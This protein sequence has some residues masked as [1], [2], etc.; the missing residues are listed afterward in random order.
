MDAKLLLEGINDLVEKKGISKDDVLT[1][2]KEAIIKAY[3]K[4]IGDAGD[5]RIDLVITDETFDLQITKTVVKDEDVDVDYLDIALSEAKKLKKGVKVGDEIAVSI[6]L[7]VLTRVSTN[8]VKSVLKQKL[9]EAEKRALFEQY[10]DRMDEMVTGTVENSDERGGITVKLG[11]SSVYLS[12]KDLI[13][14]E[15]FADNESIRMYV[16][17]VSTNEKGPSIKLSRSC[18]GFV[19]RLFEEEIQDIANGTVIIKNIV[20]A[21]GIRSKVAVYTNNINVDCV[22]SC[23]GSNGHAIKRI[24]DQLGHNL[25]DKEKID[26]IRYSKTDGLYII[27]ALRPA[28]AL[29]VALTKTS[30]D[31]NKA[32]VIIADDTMSIALGRKGSNARLASKLTGYVLDIHEESELATN[33]ELQNLDFKTAD[34]FALIEKERV[35]AENYERYL[36]Q[37]KSTELASENKEVK[38]EKENVPSFSVDT[39]F[40][41]EKNKPQQILDEDLIDEVEEVKEEKVVEAPVVEEKAP[42]VV[43]P[44]TEVKTTTTLESLEAQLESSKKKESS[45]VV[46]KTSKRPHN[47]TEE[48]QPNEEVKHEKKVVPQMD[49]YTKEELE[50]LDNELLDDDYDYDDEDIDYDEYD[51]YYDDD[52]K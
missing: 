44:T 24:V 27:D 25:R 49:I 19:K 39:S 3:A 26:I 11:H 45:K 5:A 30:D 32:V 34:D 33:E 7:N 42:E 20:R 18:E 28:V 13:G 21:A 8:V 52:N 46:H 36:A 15:K 6:P 1:S 14:D 48:E 16:D 2:L 22:S 35:R 12:K 51:K 10:K 47:I 17:N 38:G 37:I 29:K 23:I 43:V 41:V 4:E 40:G 50:D 31:K 9:G